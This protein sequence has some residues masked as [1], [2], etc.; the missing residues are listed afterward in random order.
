MGIICLHLPP[1]QIKYGKLITVKKKV[2]L[3]SSHL[4][5]VEETHYNPN[6]EVRSRGVGHYTFSADNATRAEQMT[7]L[8][9]ARE[10]TDQ[11][12]EATKKASEIRR[13]KIELR[14]KEIASKKRKREAD[15]FLDGLGMEF[16][17]FGDIK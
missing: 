11:Q 7:A 8:N 10:A 13:E 3:P 1:T 12:R 14:R 17:H 4:I 16:G 9:A 5:S 6:A 15:K 2:G